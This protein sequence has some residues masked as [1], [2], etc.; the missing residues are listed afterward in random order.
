MINK[1]SERNKEPVRERENIQVGKCTKEGG[2]E[3]NTNQGVKR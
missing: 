3:I 2:A 1:C